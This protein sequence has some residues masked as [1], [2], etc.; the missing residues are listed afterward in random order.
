MTG[1]GSGPGVEPASP[2]A[3]T[4][5][6]RAS[7]GPPAC[8]TVWGT[9]RPRHH[10]AAPGR[11]G[12]ATQGHRVARYAPFKGH[13]P[14]FA[15]A[16]IPVE[17]S[18]GRPVTRFQDFA[19]LHRAAGVDRATFDPAKFGGTGSRARVLASGHAPRGGGLR[20]VPGSRPASGIPAASCSS[21]ALGRSPVVAI[22]QRVTV[23]RLAARIIPTVGFL[24]NDAS[25]T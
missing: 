5:S 17:G 24:P 4:S 14:I 6:R 8:P 15:P 19:V 22:F 13:L 7:A 2:G 9:A 3:R 20:P 11:H 21:E 12:M 18:R 1:P 10:R 16:T 23:K 25:S